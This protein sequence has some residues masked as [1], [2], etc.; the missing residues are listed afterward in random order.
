M[1]M[2]LVV[3]FLGGFFHRLNFAHDVYTLIIVNMAQFITPECLQS[4]IRHEIGE[5]KRLRKDLSLVEHIPGVANFSLMVLYNEHFI[6][7]LTT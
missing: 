1:L 2:L 4:I 3:A 7:S 6:A 5:L